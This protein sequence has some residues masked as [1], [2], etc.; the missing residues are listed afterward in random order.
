MEEK[1][2]LSL[3]YL[4]LVVTLI[5][6]LLS[7]AV[8]SLA[9]RD[10]V[11]QDLQRQGELL[12][13]AYEDL[14]DDAALQKF[15]TNDLRITL[16][17]ADGVVLFESQANADTM[18]SHL[19][20]PEIVQALATGVGAGRRTS[21]T[22]GAVE[23][24]YAK[25]QSNG[26]VLRISMLAQSVLQ[27]YGRAAPYLVG[28]FFLLLALSVAVAVLL[29]RRLLRPIRRLPAILDNPDAGATYPELVPLVQELRAQR[30]A[31]EQMRQEF[32]AN[33][34]HELKT[35]LTTIGGYAEMIETG[36]AKGE[37]VGRFAGKIR[38]ESDRML[39]LIT[40]IIR[41]SRLDGAPE[42]PHTESVDL[43]E[44]ADGCAETLAQSALARSIRMSVT[45]EHTT[46]T[47][48]HSEIWEIVYNLT[49]N[50][51]RYNRDGGSVELIV[52]PKAITVR[53]SGIGIPPEHQARIFERFYRV[54]KSHSRATGGTGLGLSIVKH[55]AERNGAQITLH[56]TVHIGTTITVTFP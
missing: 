20:R 55:A 49:D 30:A 12:S 3:F 36:M 24:Y 51:I 39:T 52:T 53:D 46:I 38:K 28:I 27:I 11:E 25:R 5:A 34:S 33:V 4:G 31:R 16:I 18:T 35:P 14:P 32:T 2:S 54:D 9:Y 45:G 7:G 50:A 42:E 44:I 19:D 1:V 15:A 22:I 8:F 41:L 21:D 6:I 40:D 26:N 37:D 48:N 10:Q 43:R 13:C 17:A 47:G 29:T 23:Y 56:S